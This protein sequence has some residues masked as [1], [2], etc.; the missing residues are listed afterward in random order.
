[1]SAVFLVCCHLDG[2]LLRPLAFC[3]FRGARL[4]VAS[5]AISVELLPCAVGEALEPSAAAGQGGLASW[6]SCQPCG[7]DQLGLWRDTRPRLQ[8][9]GPF[10]NSSS[11]DELQSDMA[12][13]STQL[14][15]RERDAAVCR[16]CPPLA[17]CPGG[18]VVVPQPGWWHSAANSTAVHR[19]PYAPACGRGSTDDQFSL[20]QHLLGQRTHG[21]LASEPP[22]A[23][24]TMAR[25]SAVGADA[26]SSALAWCQGDWYGSGWHPGAAVVAAAV[27]GGL[28]PGVSAATEVCGRLGCETAQQQASG[29]AVVPP[30]LL[31]YDESLTPGLDPAA[32]AAL[33]YAQL[34]CAPSY[35]GNLCAA[36]QPGYYSG[37]RFQCSG[38]PSVFR[39]ACLGLLAFLGGL[40]VVL[41]TAYATLLVDYTSETEWRKAGS[42]ELL[43]VSKSCLHLEATAVLCR[44]T[45]SDVD[46]KLVACL[47]LP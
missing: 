12:R 1:M 7:Q 23:T 17:Q 3:G 26:R 35:T 31:W 20:W 42:A 10:G 45:T 24:D 30:C 39:A 13:I 28:L 25:G 15:D 33:S 16:V 4:Q 2:V 34:Q 18:A 8:V 22:N 9:R 32:F 29:T 46:A 38:C 19:C 41:V 43:K 11:V 21:Q 37:S 6:T 44:G 47:G 27:K 14:L 5:L 36:C 40:V